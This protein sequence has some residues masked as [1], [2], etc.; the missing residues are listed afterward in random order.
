M[1]MKTTALITVGLL[2][3]SASAIQLS[4][5]PDRAMYKPGEQVT[6]TL[7]YQATERPRPLFAK[8]S[9][10]HLRQEV[11]TE[12]F[13]LDPSGNGSN[14][15][16]WTPPTDPTGYGATIEITDETSDR[17][18]ARVETAFDVHEIWTER[19]RYGFLSDFAPADGQ[20][21]DRVKNLA[22]YH[23]NALQFYDWMYRHDNHLPPTDVFVDPL[24]RTLSMHT[25]RQRIEEA[26]SVGMAAMPYTTIYG[27]SKAYGNPHPEQGLYKSNGSTWDFG[28]NFLT[29]MNPASEGWREHIYSEYQK[30]LEAE[31]FDGLHIDQYGDPKVAYDSQGKEINLAP[32]VPDFL[33]GAQKVASQ[34]PGRDTVVFNLV[35]DW[36]NDT[37]SP[38]DLSFT[39]V[40]V[41]PPHDDYAS[42]RDIVYHN[43]ELSGG[44]PVVLA[45]YLTAKADAATKLLNSVIAA[46]GASHLELGED[47]QLLGD[48]YFPRY[49]NPSQ[50]L[51]G[52]LKRNYD[53]TVRYQDV[54]YGGS[55]NKTL[56]D[57][58]VTSHPFSVG[59]YPSK[60]IWGLG[61]NLPGKQ[62][63][64]LINLLSSPAPVWKFKQPDPQKTRNVQVKVTR[65]LPVGQVWIATP[66][67]ADLTPQ[68]LP[69][70]QQGN[71]VT[72]TV[73]DLKVWTMIVLEDR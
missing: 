60:K 44:K 40:E 43:Q 17:V 68:L 8:V 73:P 54:L 39:Y 51:K 42:L 3:G 7:S 28:E 57:L 6:L 34:F 31:P 70:K 65:T 36:P 72:F 13:P 48:P 38:T 20:D 18:W 46:A 10:S 37:V 55:P 41:W 23:I 35:N 22:S 53:F 25:V 58:A 4:L 11:H 33:K 56:D 14:Q 32:V 67:H 5:T 21:T 29:T 15:V 26:H 63:F 66:D 71:T 12:K 49:E 59:D 64:H 52:W 50:E 2:G 16:T 62:V 27:A 1:N 69:F 24:G 9:I 45:A 47:E 30:V 19:P 61:R